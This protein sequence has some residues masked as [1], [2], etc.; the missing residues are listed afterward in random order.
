M[1]VGP[2][3]STPVTPTSTEFEELRRRQQRKSLLLLLIC[4]FLGAGA[5]ILFKKAGNQMGASPGLIE[6]LTNMPLVSG[7][8]LYGLSLVL[9]SYALRH[10]ELSSLYPL[11]SLTYVWV[12]L[13]SIFVFDEPLTVVKAAGVLTIMAGVAVISRS[14]K[15]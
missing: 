9:L 15:Q 14:T 3:A 2:L 6:V 8:A 7:Y 4:T 10:D 5:Q 12:L 1:R 11:I 13:L